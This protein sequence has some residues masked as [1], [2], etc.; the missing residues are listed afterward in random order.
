MK[1][2]VTAQDLHCHIRPTSELC[3]LFRFHS[4]VCRLWSSSWGTIMP[5]CRK[6]K[7]VFFWGSD[8][9]NLYTVS[10][11][12]HWTEI[13]AY[14]SATTRMSCSSQLI[15]ASWPN[16]SNITQRST[17]DTIWQHTFYDFLMI[18]SSNSRSLRCNLHCCMCFLPTTKRADM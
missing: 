9:E 1:Q 2:K 3:K 5:S 15:L 17:A 10:T 6:L 13:N 11:R 4:A 8:I 14:Y 7:K 18:F 12:L 16:R